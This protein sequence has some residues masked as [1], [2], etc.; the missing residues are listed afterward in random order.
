MSLEVAWGNLGVLKPQR[1][2]T[3]G[4]YSFWYATQLLAGLGGTKGIVYPRSEEMRDAGVTGESP[5]HYAKRKAN[6]GQGEILSELEMMTVV[7]HYGYTGTPYPSGGTDNRAAFI[8]GHLQADR[9]VLVAYLMDDVGPTTDTHTGVYGPNSVDSDSGSH[10][11]LII[12]EDSTDYR[13]LEPNNPNKITTCAKN[14]LLASNAAADGV[15]FARFWTKTGPVNLEEFGDFKWWIKAM[16][17]AGR[18]TTLYD[19]GKKSR[20]SLNEVLIAVS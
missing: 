4:L 13:Y 7:Q 8:T 6:S 14:A 1:Q 18:K 2:G 15:K 16:W 10:W 12:N 11:S 19:L 20:Q 9:P 17:K 3:C 5:R